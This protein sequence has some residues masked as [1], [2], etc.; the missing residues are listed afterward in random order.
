MATIRLENISKSFPGVQA[1]KNINQEIKSGEFF[2]LLGPS[3]CGKTTLLRTIAGFY[4]QDEGHIYIDDNLIDDVPAYDRNTG[5]VFQNYA[6]FPH[7]T[8]FENVAFGLKNR[9]LPNNVIKKKVENALEMAR[10][11]GF[12]NRTPDQLSGGQQQRVGLARAMVIEPKVLLMDEPLSNLD[13]KLRVQMREE[14]REIQKKLGITTIYVT[15]DQEEALVISDRIAVMQAG[16]IHQVGTSW[17]IYKNPADIFVA[18]FVGETNF[19]DGKIQKIEKEKVSIRVGNQIIK[20]RNP[21]KDIEVKRVKI[22]VRPEEITL[23]KEKIEDDDSTILEGKVIKNTFTGPLVRY[24]V[25][26]DS[27]VQLLVETHKP[28]QGYLMQVG[29]SVFLTIPLNSIQYFDFDTGQRI[30]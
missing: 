8:V 17:E 21:E 18:A 20:A 16:K 12:E 24:L 27:E 15:H 10:L 26:C 11:T 4:H 28:E 29:T 30:R 2:T 6:V 22:S 7:M 25:D 3:G 19:M 5:M 1:L 14:I 23:I 9:K 13:A